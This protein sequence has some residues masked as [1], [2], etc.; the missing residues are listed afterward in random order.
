MKILHLCL[1]NYYWE[2]MGY[3]ENLLTRYHTRARHKVII[4]TSEHI[5]KKERC[6]DKDYY[7]NDFGAEVHAL[8]NKFSGAL[9]GLRL[10]SGLYS[11]IE[12]HAPEIIFVHGGQFL[13][14]K[15]VIKYKKKHPEV[16]IYIDQH[17]DYYNSP[18]NTFK[19]RVLAK[20]I[21]GHYMRKAVKYTEVFW[22]VTPWR[23]TYL[24]DVYG[25]PKDKIGLLIMGGDDDIIDFENKDGIR[26]NIRQALE[27]SDDDFVVVTGGKIDRAKN[28]HLLMQAVT[29][30][31]NDK[32]KL[33]VFGRCNDEMKP[34]ILSFAEHSSIRYIDW[35]PAEKVYDYFLA[36]DLAVFPGTHSVLWEQVCA[37]GIPGLYKDWEGMR[38]VNVCGNSEFLYEDSA[39]EIKVKLETLLNDR[40]KYEAMSLAAKSCEDDFKYS[41]IAKKAIQ[42]R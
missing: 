31:D 38:H 8:K 2:D 30:L 11:E 6:G 20:Y 32:L 33:I 36:S 9:F 28:I 4:V 37:C 5:F 40:S 35:L 21:Y 14:L 3:Q 17:A 25:I 27:L 29:E 22:G 13:S 7:I 42:W 18:V 39:E 12:K 41:E 19:S 26:R 15:D 23:C 16:R 24:N 34:Q 1:A 10:F